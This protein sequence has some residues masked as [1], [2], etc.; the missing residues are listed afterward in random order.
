M[1]VLL[2][3]VKVKVEAEAAVRATARV[4][5]IKGISTVVTGIATVTA[6]ASIIRADRRK[7]LAEESTLTSSS[8]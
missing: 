8:L 5:A 3:G 6:I 7:R 1:P 2:N 4:I